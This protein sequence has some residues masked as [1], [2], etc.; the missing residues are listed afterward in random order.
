MHLEGRKREKGKPRHQRAWLSPSLH[1][2]RSR[3]PGEGG[4][5]TSPSTS[6][7]PALTTRW[8][9]PAAEGQR[10]APQLRLPQEKRSGS[11]RRLRRKPRRSRTRTRALVPSRPRA[12]LSFPA[13]SRPNPGRQSPREPIRLQESPPAYHVA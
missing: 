6:P 5:Q 11:L 4:P 10:A 9:A 8:S 3:A 7:S 1:P 2:T 13:Q 12:R